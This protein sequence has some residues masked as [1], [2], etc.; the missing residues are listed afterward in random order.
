MTTITSTTTTSA[1]S[2][3]SAALTAADSGTG[4]DYDALIEA[5]VAQ[6]LVPADRIETTITENEARIAAYTELQT[7]LLAVNDSLD[8]L[9]NR[10]ESTGADENLFDTRTAYLS[11]GGSTS[12]DDVLAVSVEDGTETG[13]YSVEVV[14]LATRHKI[15]A[16]TTSSQTAALGLSGTL[17]VGVAGGTAVAVA[18]DAD[19]SLADLRD[20]INDESD[21]TGVKA[22][23]VQVSAGEYQLIL[24]ATDTGQEIALDD[25]GSGLT[26]GLGFTDADGAFA[27][28]LVA[29][30]DAIIKVD[31]VT[32]TRDSNTIDDAVE[33][34][35]FDLYSALPGETINV[36]VS[37]DLAEIKTAITD[38]V[39][40]YNALRAF[41]LTQQA[42]S[43]DGTA[44]ADATLFADSLLRQINAAV[45]DALNT[46]V[47]TAD[48]DVLSL[49]TLGLSFDSDD[50]TLELDETALNEALTDNLEDVRLLLGLNMTASSNDLQLLRY[51]SGTVRDTSFS[52]DIAVDDDGNLVSASVDGDS[53]LFEISD[54]RIIGVEG[55]AYEGLVFVYTGKSATVDVSFSNGLAELMYSAI[56]GVANADDGSIT[57]IVEQIEDNNATLEARVERIQESAETYRSYLTAYYARLEAAA[58]E[59]KILLEQLQYSDD[60]DD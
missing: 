24:T 22:S 28:E 33:G 43:S 57:E 15:G 47:T 59:A 23:I 46:S 60:D 7:L 14:Q 30:Q 26:A 16:A 50:N 1:S 19:M 5:A 55:S 42:T 34:I 56:D 41:V 37:A 49:A 12:A 36:E 53:S 11:G 44:G 17:S 4:L 9:R 20:A 45:Y 29:V 8:G 32:I 27:N 39:D 35:S 38:F 13:I 51:D 21:T 52:L 31:G 54:S 2:T 25:S 58:E 40:A 10:G 6:R 48:G 3:G 18:V